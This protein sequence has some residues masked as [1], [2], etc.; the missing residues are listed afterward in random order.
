M[1]AETPVESPVENS[2]AL[3]GL[4]EN[5]VKN[6]VNSGTRRLGRP[7][8]HNRRKVME[9][10]C[11][12]VASGERLQDVCAVERVDPSTI[13]EWAAQDAELG[14]M[15][16]RAREFC[17]DAWFDQ[18]IAIA[19]GEDGFGD[20]VQRVLEAEVEGSALSALERRALINSVTASVVNRDRLR[21]DT[22]KWAAAKLAPKRYGKAVEET[23][24]RPD[25]NAVDAF[26]QR[27]HEQRR[28]NQLAVEEERERNSNRIIRIIEDV[29][30]NEVTPQERRAYLARELAVN[31][32]D[33]GMLELAEQLDKLGKIEESHPIDGPPTFTFDI[34]KPLRPPITT[35]AIQH[36]PR[37]LDGRPV[38]NEP[39]EPNDEPESG[40][41][42]SGLAPSRSIANNGSR[43]HCRR[44]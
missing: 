17:A 38:R 6:P 29:S 30:A 37:G 9:R 8:K 19:H 1:T 41:V 44:L 12:R 22:L 31:A 20:V 15:Y 24:G 40:P 10:V 27:R 25:A 13:R 39:S 3:C 16:A 32:R 7:R 43:A 26:L 21:V 36:V 5:P 11:G 42:A 4:T 18:A 23:A 34:G 35:I 33:A 14:A 28:L 2:V